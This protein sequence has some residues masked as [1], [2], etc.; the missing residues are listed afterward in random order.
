VTLVRGL[1]E[2]PIDSMAHLRHQVHIVLPVHRDDHRTA[3]PAPLKEGVPYRPVTVLGLTP[4]D[5][6]VVWLLYV[7]FRGWS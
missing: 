6:A 1:T 4:D 2:R 5:W 3:A 7:V